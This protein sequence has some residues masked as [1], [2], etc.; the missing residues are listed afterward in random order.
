MPGRISL[1]TSAQ[2]L[3]EALSEPFPMPAQPDFIRSFVLA[4]R[5]TLPGASRQM[6]R[7]GAGGRGT[8]RGRNANTD[9][10]YEID[11]SADRGPLGEDQ[12]HPRPLLHPYGD[13]VFVSKVMHASLC[14]SFGMFADEPIYRVDEVAGILECDIGH[15]YDL[16]NLEKNEPGSGLVA[17]NIGASRKPIYRVRHSA[18]LQFFQRRSTQLARD[19]LTES[20]PRAER[21]GK[22]IDAPGNCAEGRDDSFSARRAALKRNEKGE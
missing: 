4:S 22:I 21:N 8:T 2:P 15:V 16:I 13:R 12:I 7:M 3:V 14:L 17:V 11:D 20:Q 18:L 19:A 10:R 6:L 1:G 5:Q 9:A